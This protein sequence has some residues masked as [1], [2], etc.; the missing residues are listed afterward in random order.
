MTGAT[1]SNLPLR[2]PSRVA[3]VLFPIVGFDWRL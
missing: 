1:S 3:A 2:R